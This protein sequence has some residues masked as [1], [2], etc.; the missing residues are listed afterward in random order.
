MHIPRKVI[1]S[2]V[3]FVSDINEGDIGETVFTISVK[4][5]DYN[6][7]WNVFSAEC[8]DEAGSEIKVVFFGDVL[9]IT[10]RT[11]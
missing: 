6:N 4:V 7:D 5:A 1:Q 8:E 9:Y 11:Y 10:Q 3:A 2:R